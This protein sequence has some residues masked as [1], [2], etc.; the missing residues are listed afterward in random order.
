MYV[1]VYIYIYHSSIIYIYIYIYIYMGPAMSDLRVTWTALLLIIIIIII[2]L[3]III[4][5]SLVLISSL[6]SL[7]LL[8][9]LLSLFVNNDSSAPAILRGSARLE[10]HTQWNSRWQIIMYCFH[11]FL[12]YCILYIKRG[13][14]HQCW[15]PVYQLERHT[16]SFQN[17]MFAFAA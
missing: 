7:L 4:M 3:I 9:L 12:G 2:I 6:S 5:L 14:V 8:S 11:G 10:R 1:C 16:V 17:I 15:S 13:I